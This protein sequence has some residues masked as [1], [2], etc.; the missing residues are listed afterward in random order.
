[1]PVFLCDCG[2]Q[3]LVVPDLFAMEIAIINHL[4]LHE[5]L[6]GVAISEEF[7]TKEIICLLAKQG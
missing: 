1:M 3:I 6:T 7:L 4:K 5:E 2:V